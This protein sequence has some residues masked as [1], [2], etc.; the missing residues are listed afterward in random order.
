MPDFLPFL[1][2]LTPN[3]VVLAP[4]LVVEPRVLFLLA[5]ELADS[6]VLLEGEAF[7]LS[8]LI[9]LGHMYL[10]V[11]SSTGGSTKKG[12]RYQYGGI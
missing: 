10:E 12:V 4:D 8:F 5:G 2:F 7:F 6:I 1:V 11:I 3:F 9:Y